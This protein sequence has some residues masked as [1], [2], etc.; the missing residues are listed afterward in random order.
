MR[1]KKK[2]LPEKITVQKINELHTA[3]ATCTLPIQS[4]IKSPN[5]NSNQ[6]TNI[7]TIQSHIQ[8]PNKNHISPIIPS[9]ISITQS[10]NKN[11]NHSIIQSN[12]NDLKQNIISIDSNIDIINKSTKKKKKKLIKIMMLLY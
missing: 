11:N 4:H 8:S 9:N 2:K 5:I 12:N 10:S 6:T 3:T 7:S 1:Y